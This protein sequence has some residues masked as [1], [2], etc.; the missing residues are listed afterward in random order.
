MS[1]GKNWRELDHQFTKHYERLGRARKSESIPSHQIA[2]KPMFPHIAH[3]KNFKEIGKFT[4]I[5]GVSYKSVVGLCVERIQLI[6]KENERLFNQM[7]SIMSNQSSRPTSICKLPTPL[8]RRVCD[9]EQRQ[10]ATMMANQPRAISSRASSAIS[11][12]SSCRRRGSSGGGGAPRH[13]ERSRKKIQQE[14][15]QILKRILETP[16]SYD[17]VKWTREEHQRQKYVRNLKKPASKPFTALR[18]QRHSTFNPNRS[19]CSQQ[20]QL[21]ESQRTTTARG[22]SNNNSSRRH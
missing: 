18:N 20:S 21:S 10:G 7:R 3:K 8:L 15:G 1:S 2:L 13:I 19:I 12:R 9:A 22:N 6:N 17:L 16:R 14:N 11:S 5:F 4:D